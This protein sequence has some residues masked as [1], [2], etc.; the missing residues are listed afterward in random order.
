M[1][2]HQI[3]ALYTM[4]ED[5]TQEILKLV[6]SRYGLG[7]I[8]SLETSKR[9]QLE[10]EIEGI[11]RHEYALLE[12]A[13]VEEWRALDERLAKTEIGQLLQAR[14]AISEQILDLWDE[15]LQDNDPE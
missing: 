6:A 11:E 13:T 9:Q 15:G 2:E 12:G 14:H 4:L 1:T 10:E 8:G 3:S 7:D 5:E